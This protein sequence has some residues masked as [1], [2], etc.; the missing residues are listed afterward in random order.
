MTLFTRRAARQAFR[1]SLIGLLVPREH[2]KTMTVL[3]SVVPGGNRQHLHHFLHDARWDTARLNQR[4]DSQDVVP[5]IDKDDFASDRPTERACEKCG[6][7][8]NF[9]LLRGTI[10]R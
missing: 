1:H 10:E 8:A 3:A 5:L 9:G 7:V 2:H 6:S 4:L